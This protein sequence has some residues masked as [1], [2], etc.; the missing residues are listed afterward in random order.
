MMRDSTLVEAHRECENPEGISKSMGRGKAGFMAFHPLS[1]P[2]RVFARQIS[3]YSVPLQCPALATRCSP[4]VDEGIGYLSRAQSLPNE[5][6][7]PNIQG[8]LTKIVLEEELT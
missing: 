2:W 3:R 6:L 5:V 1:F 8:V 4:L 7:F